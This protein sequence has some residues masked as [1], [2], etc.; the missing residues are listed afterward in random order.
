MTYKK[1]IESCRTLDEL[2]DVWKT[3]EAVNQR[4]VCRGQTNFIKFDYAKNGFISDGIINDKCWNEGIYPKILF[5]IKENS[6]EEKEIDGDIRAELRKKEHRSLKIEGYYSKMSK[7]AGSIFF[8]DEKHIDPFDYHNNVGLFDRIAIMGISKENKTDLINDPDIIDLYAEIN[9]IEI[10]K[11]IELIDPDI[12]VC[13]SV[14]RTLITYVYGKPQ[15]INSIYEE[16][17]MKYNWC[18]L[19]PVNGKKRLF[20]DYLEPGWPDLVS[21]YGLANIYQQALINDFIPRY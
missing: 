11:E 12:I 10:K 13:C 17:S 20:I 8:T 3:K 16:D 15:T 5:V 1:R 14:F 9:Q 18:C 6:L 19:L 21:Y 2:F 4:Y 7:W